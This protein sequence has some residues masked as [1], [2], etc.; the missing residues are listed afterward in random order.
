MWKQPGMLSRP[1][2][3]PAQDPRLNWGCSLAPPLPSHPPLPCSAVV[4]CRPPPTLWGMGPSR[5]WCGDTALGLNPSG[6][7]YSTCVTSGRFFKLSVETWA[8]GSGLGRM[9]LLSPGLSGKV[10]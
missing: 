2:A 9:P 4:T 10:T 6:V 8:V 7:L 3:F 5:G 1:Q